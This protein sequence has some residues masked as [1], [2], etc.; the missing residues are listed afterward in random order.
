MGLFDFDWD[1][2]G[3]Q[4]EWLSAFDWDKDGRAF[5]WADWDK[6]GAPFELQAPALAN[7]IQDYQLHNESDESANSSAAQLDNMF[8]NNGFM[9]YMQGL[10]ASHGQ[11]AIE[12]R[13]YN[14]LEAEKARQFAASEAEKN[15]AWQEQ[16]SSTSYQRAVA[17]LQAAGLNPILAYKQ[18]G[19]VTGTGATAQPSS[20]SYSVGGGDTASSLMNA[21]ANLFSS[22]AQMTDILSKILPKSKNKAGC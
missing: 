10:L 12:N 3:K 22:A 6:D 9:D 17:D 11:E 14:S 18:G 19:A 21:F 16:M 20:A 2:D 1:G 5:E 8:S 4:F 13:A 15:R 7:D